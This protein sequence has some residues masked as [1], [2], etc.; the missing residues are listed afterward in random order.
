MCT[1]YGG[2]LGKVAGWVG[3]RAKGKTKCYRPLQT[4]Q[5]GPQLKW[6]VDCTGCGR[7]LGTGRDNYNSKAE[8]GK[9]PERFLRQTWCGHW[10]K[11]RG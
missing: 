2:P 8:N 4:T 6:S 5:G 7:Y 11:P 9:A 1:Q 3:K 10:L